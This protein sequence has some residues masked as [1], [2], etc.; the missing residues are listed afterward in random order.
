MCT[1]F[2]QKIPLLKAA[3]FRYFKNMS[4]IWKLR[5]LAFADYNILIEIK[6]IYQLHHFILP[7]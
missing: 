6:I 7:F 2:L 4:S 3:N 1:L 5:K